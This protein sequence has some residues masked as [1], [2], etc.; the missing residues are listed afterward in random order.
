MSV[1]VLDFDPYL[2][3]IIHPTLFMH[4]FLRR[5]PSIW[6][7]HERTGGNDQCR[8]LHP[9][10]HLGFLASGQKVPRQH[11]VN[12]DMDGTRRRQSCG[13]RPPAERASPEVR[14]IWAELST[15][16]VYA[17]CSSYGF[18]LH[19]SHDPLASSGTVCPSAIGDDPHNRTTTPARNHHARMIPVPTVMGRLYCQVSACTVDPPPLSHAHDC[20]ASYTTFFRRIFALKAEGRD[21]SLSPFS[22]S[23]I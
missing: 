20:H 19:P 18:T 21:K 2:V 10:E 13:T 8:S 16:A 23:I 9:P 3:S 14:R 11:I 1:S 15:P 17:P 4:G 22:I 7:L 12:S 6:S 5:S